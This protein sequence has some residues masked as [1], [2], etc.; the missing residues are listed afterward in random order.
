MNFVKNNLILLIILLLGAFLRINADTFLS[1]YN[2]DEFAIISIAKLDI[3]NLF[4]ALSREDYH[5]PLYY[6]IAHFSNFFN[7]PYLFLRFL[8]IIIS[9]GNI[10]IFYKIG[11]LL[12]NKR[13]GYFLALFLAINHLQISTVNFIKFYCLDIFLTSL[14]ILFLLD[15]IK[16]NKN[17]KS[18]T[19]CNF[20]I[21]LSFTFGFVFV[22]L[23][24]LFLYFYKKDKE[25]F[26]YFYLANIALM[27]YLPILIFQ[28]KSA[29]SGIISTHGSYPNLSILAIYNYFNDYFSPL[30]NHS[31]NTKTI[32]STL[33]LIEFFT[34]KNL[35]SLLEF[36]LFSF[37]PT[38]IGLYGIYISFNDKETKLLFQIAFSYLAFCFVLILFQITGMIPI[39][40]FYSGIILIILAIYGLSKNK[41]KINEILL[42]ALILV[43]LIIPNTFS[44]PEN[45]IF[46]NIDE[47]IKE[48]SKNTPIIMFDGAR[49]A[50]YYY[51]EKNIFALDY[52]EM[53]G[54]H[55]KK[56]IKI[57]YGENISKKAN[58]KNLKELI[59]PIILNNEN[60]GETSDYLE[61]NLFSKLKKKEKIILAFCSNGS[62]F[63]INENQIKK[64]L[65][66][67]YSHK[68][69]TSTLNY[70]INKKYQQ[71]ITQNELGE[72]IQSYST[73]LIINEI[74]KKFKSIKIE[75][76]IQDKTGKYKKI[77]IKISHKKL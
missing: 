28:T 5:A 35:F 58:K 39:Y 29:F 70:L 54:S 43:H 3:I 46:G 6:L 49:F 13:T 17:L 9:L 55:S 47:K 20:F 75:Q 31:Y 30:I 73:K 19:I 57:F 68:L 16:N 4:K 52:E 67:P 66:K 64:D 24:Y 33:L 69:R 18:L 53:Q 8:N 76:F 27:I 45:K 11:K 63:I 25:L 61:K 32:E 40:H 42:F 23:E 1:G 56:L 15:F 60:K 14:S 62:N 34:F 48:I 7:E 59:K 37:L 71:E 72:I 38:V 74:E 41:I 44:K 65:N 26:K 2:Y 77:I 12:K 10:Y 51:K 22:F 21:I 50:K 36:I